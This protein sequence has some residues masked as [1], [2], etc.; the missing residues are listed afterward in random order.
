MTLLI[1]L[2]NEF[3]FLSRYLVNC[4]YVV[5]V[6]IGTPVAAVSANLTSENQK[7]HKQ[8]YIFCNISTE[9]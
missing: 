8:K 3:E 9:Q 5:G 1:A 7:C 2:I 4:V 6:A